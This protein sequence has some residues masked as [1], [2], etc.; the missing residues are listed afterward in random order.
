MEL[1]RDYNAAVDLVGRNLTAG[2]GSKIAY[3]DD[4]ESCTYAQLAERVDRAA[5]V[6]RS[7]D[8]RR[9][10]RIAIAMLDCADWVALFLGAIKAGIVPVAMNTLLNR[11]DYE[12]QLRDSRSRPLFVSEPLLKNF[13]GLQCPHLRHAVPDSKFKG[14]LARQEP[15][16]D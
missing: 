6:L 16:A 4:T 15:R 12:Y 8:I 5:N 14:L 9:E 13:E 10:E 1:P 2:R 11:D 3:I 7:M